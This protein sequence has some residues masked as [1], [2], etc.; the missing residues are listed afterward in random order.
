MA[1]QQTS[2]RGRLGA[3]LLMGMAVGAGAM[4]VFDP[5]SGRRRRALARDQAAR[6][7]SSVDELVT[8]SLPK[9][10]EYLSGV[11]RGT[12]H[13]LAGAQDRDEVP[14]EDRFITDRVMSIVFRDPGIP[15]GDLN[16]NTVERVV[17]L[18]GHVD[19]PSVATEVERRV[20]GV[21]GVRDVV[22]VINRP[23]VDPS[24]V[25]ADHVRHEE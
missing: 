18:H 5:R 16:V 3:G 14:D 10:A 1:R 2:G 23:K 13:R 12:R 17:Y 20:R 24:A 8:E 9:K 11:A 6:L 7:G 4:F 15:K 19:D 21:E 25:R 22:N